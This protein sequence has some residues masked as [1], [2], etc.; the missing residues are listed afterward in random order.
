MQIFLRIIKTAWHGFWR[1]GWLSLVAIFIMMQV[2]LLV[3]I[4]TSL[5]LGVAQ[6]IQAINERI[7]VAVFFKDYVPE[8]DILAFQQKITNLSGVKSIQFV[9][10]QKALESYV[11]SNQRNKELLDIVGNDS[12]FFPASLEIK[13]DN[14]NLLETVVQRVKDQDQSGLIAQTSLEKNQ[15]V[16]NKL[17]NFNRLLMWGNLIVSFILIVIALLIIFNTI[18]ITIFTRKEEIEIMKL[19]GATDWYIRWPF[20]LEGVLYGIMGAILAFL[21]TLAVYQGAGLLLGKNYWSM[22]A[23]GG[24]LEIF[25]LTFA[26]K[27]FV[28]QLF[29]GVLVGSISSY[30][31]TRRY[32]RI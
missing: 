10:H 21:L 1:N 9:S 23:V 8:N 20:I 2:L 6:A 3:G 28:F 30:S 18:R 22:Q 4:F 31:S 7:D 14:P 5:N 15:V 12:T 32:L 13:V 24:S 27:L 11:A 19:V 25:S 26:A 17:R 29:F 16:I